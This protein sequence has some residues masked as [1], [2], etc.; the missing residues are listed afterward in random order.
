MAIS[1]SYV[2]LPEG[3]ITPTPDT[4]HQPDPLSARIEVPLLLQVPGLALFTS[5]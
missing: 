1:N 2:K 4:A 3:R 5:W